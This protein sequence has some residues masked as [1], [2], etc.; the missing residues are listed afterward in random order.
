VFRGEGKLPSW[1]GLSP[2]V[3]RLAALNSA[4]LGRARVA[5][6]STSLF[7]ATKDV[8]ARAKRGHDGRRDD[9]IWP[10]DA[11]G[12]RVRLALLMRST[13]ARFGTWEYE[14]AHVLCRGEGNPR[15]QG[16][17]TRATR[18]AR[19]GLRRRRKKDGA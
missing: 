8:D 5:V 11:L 3:G 7:E 4:Q 6:P 15:R 1:P 9:S 10:D 14:R 12:R 17:R 13:R 18:A 16:L 19:R 2:Q